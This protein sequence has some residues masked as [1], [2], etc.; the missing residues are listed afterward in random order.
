[1]T[2]QTSEWPSTYVPILG[3][4]DPLCDDF[5]KKKVEEEE[6]DDEEGDEAE[7]GRVVLGECFSR[8]GG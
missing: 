6:E 1:M 3:C 8:R 2:G 4:S 5:E 7:E